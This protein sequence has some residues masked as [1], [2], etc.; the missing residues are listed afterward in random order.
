MSRTPVYAAA[1]ATVLMAVSLGAVVTVLAAPAAACDIRTDPNCVGV[2]T[3][4]PGGGGT[5]PPPGDGGGGGGGGGTTDPCAKYPAGYYEYC[6]TLKGRGCLSLY[7]QYYGSMP[8][9]QFNVFAAANGCPAVAAGANPPPTPAEL[10]V[11]AAATFRLPDPSGHRSPSEGG[12]LGGY[13]FTYINLWTYY[14]TDASTWTP[15]TATAE[16]GGNFATVTARPVSLTFDPGDGSP[17]TDC[18]GPGRPWTESDGPSAPTAG[19][20]GF[21]YG[22]VTGPG[23]D[24]PVTSTQTITWQLTWTGSNNTNGVL[25]QKTTSTAGPLNVLQVQTV[26]R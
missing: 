11:R 22:R 16:A 26:N 5:T 20:C 2:G 21:Q 25:T 19:G 1:L 13:A 3:G 15:L 14:W 8:L 10:A 6:T 17:P 9:D 4:G 18:P 7:D 24:H 12:Q 23:Y